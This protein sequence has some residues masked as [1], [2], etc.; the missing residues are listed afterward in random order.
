MYPK[1]IKEEPRVMIGEGQCAKPYSASLYNISAMSFGSMSASVRC[2]KFF[3]AVAVDL[4][5][6]EEAK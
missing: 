6:F 3:N 1:K 2:F 4:D 5:C